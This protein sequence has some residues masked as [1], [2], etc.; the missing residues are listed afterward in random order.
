MMSNVFF[1]ASKIAKTILIQK[2]I[3]FAF[4]SSCS[5]SGNTFPAAFAET[6]AKGSSSTAIMATKAS[7]STVSSTSVP[8][9]HN[10]P[11]PSTSAGRS[12]RIAP[13]S[14]IKGLGLNSDGFASAD[15]AGF[16]GQTN[17]REVL[18]SIFSTYD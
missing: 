17:A 10:A 13:H 16:V 8:P 2:I 1:A 4:L 3:E 14:H 6:D 7:T 15:T 18:F 9:A 11:L 5:K 12:S